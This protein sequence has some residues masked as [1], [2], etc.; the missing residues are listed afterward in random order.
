MKL[1]NTL[2]ALCLL[3]ALAAGLRGLAGDPRQLMEILLVFAMAQSWNLLCGYT[4]LLSFGHQAFIGLGAYALFMCTDLL[5][6]SPYWGLAASVAAAVAAALM[7]AVLLRRMR[8]AYFS[9][10]IWV[11]ADSVRLLVGQWQLAGGS[12]GLVLNVPSGFDAAALPA[13]A[14]WLAGGLAALTFGGMFWLLRSRVGLALTAIRDNERGAASAGIAT[15]QNRLLAFVLSAAI[16]GL[17]GGIY[18][19]SVLYVDPAG[20]FDLDWQIRLFFIVIVGG[21]GTLEGP[22]VGTVLYYAL[23]AAFVGNGTWFAVCEGCV[24]AAVIFI[25]P[26][27]LWGF[28]RNRTG[29]RVFPIEWATR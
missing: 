15:G 29:L 1:K 24:A 11:L 14:L 12:Q 8:D 18:F 2:P 19:L 10:G 7:M 6:V 16:C 23:R 3:G 26:Q 27:G 25:A 5:G 9:I 20:A 17:A 13:V 21:L 22:I 28:V 4:G